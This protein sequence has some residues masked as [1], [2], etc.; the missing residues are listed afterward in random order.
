MSIEID[1]ARLASAFQTQVQDSASPATGGKVAAALFG[2]A[3]VTVTNGAMTDLEALVARLK[4]DSER[5]KF[6]LLMTSLSSISQSLTDTQKRKLEQGLAL[7]EKLDALEKMLETYSDD[8]AKAKAALVVLQTKI[9]TL[10][11]L[12]KQAVEDGKE[13]NEL[14]AEQKRVRAELAAKEQTLA[15]TQGKID[16]T[17]NEIASVKGQISVIVRSIGENTLNAIAKDLAVLSDPEKAERPAEAR[18]EDEKEAET[19]PFAAIRESL[20][21]IERDINETI[22]E[23]RIETV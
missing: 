3:A 10:T 16:Q 2:G 13:H 1:T 8:E 5:A 9:D 17:K 11:K 7:S 4:S 18:K 22:V 23:N 12:I 21:K 15:E 19:D 20:A 6:S 14:V